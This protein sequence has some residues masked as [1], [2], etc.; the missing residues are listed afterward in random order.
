MGTDPLIDLIPLAVSWL[1]YF[2]IHSLMASIASKQFIA[3]RWPGGMP[4]YRMVF[5]LV[6]VLLL[7]VPL[8]LTFTWSGP[9]LW[10]WQGGWLWLSLALSLLA[11]AGL[12]ARRRRR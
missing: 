12:A 8:W 3:E 9:W 6:A 2:C 1:A 11:V 4:A 10:R 5:N 7:A